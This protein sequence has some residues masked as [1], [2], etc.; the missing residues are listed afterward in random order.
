[1]S[2]HRDLVLGTAG[3]IDHGKTALVRALTGVDTDR[4]PAEK[5]R[6]ITIDLGF[7][8]LE[9][10]SDRLALVDVPGHERFIRNM[11][12]GATGL[13]LAM[14]VV[15]ADDSVMP[16]T[17]EHLEILRLL[18]IPA[19]LVAL[20][21]CDLADSGWVDLVEEEVRALVAGT[22]LEGAPIVRTSATTGRG[23]EDLKGALARLAA[24]APGRSDP[25]LFRMA[26]DRA[27]TVAG[28]GTV[29]TGTVAGGAVAVGD[30]L[31]WF[32][33]GR[34]VRVRGLQ[35]HE[36]PVDRVGRGARAAINLGGVHHAEIRRGQELGAPGYLRSTRVLSVEVRPAG[37]APRPLR[38]RG[39]YRLHLG[40]AEVTATLA[41]L[42]SNECGPGSEAMLGQLF[43]A[44]PVVAVYGE[45]FVL[46]EES[47]PA[48][49]GGGRVL[50]PVARRIR[51]RDL[52]ARERLGRL[53]SREPAERVSAALAFL[54]MAPWTERG[55]CRDTGLTPGE[56]PAV[57]AGLAASGALVELPVGPRRTVK[58]LAEVAAD[59]ED[60]VARA[61]GRLHAARPRLSAIRRPH[62]AAALPDL[63][64]DALVFGVVERLKARGA[65]V[66]D[67]RT[68]ALKDHEPKLSQGERRLKGELAEAIHAGGFSPPDQAE[69]SAKA[70]ARASVVPELLA[71]LVDEGRVVEVGHG[72]Y[73][74]FDVDAAMR[75][76]VAERLADGSAM[77][78]ADL[79]DLLGTTR[80]FAVPIGEYLDR[81]GLT[82]REGDLRRLGEP[83]AVATAEPSAPE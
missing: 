34:V 45:P 83:H 47:P 23:I 57:V 66:G 26:I 13:D 27:F 38:H 60:R 41:L 79:R 30:D 78:M 8:A 33:E 24:G 19:G 18:E 49:L 62:L 59:L 40:T 69:L 50:Q 58:V 5:Q 17:R 39:R 21:K 28:H 20:T 9:L 70:G 12:A 48:T 11:L 36:R 75:R 82:R 81:I 74:D 16:Q 72:L 51:R 31:E 15:A 43:L 35:R 55:L 46:R 64:G 29:V 67:E 4:L 61:L 73:L 25:G 6:G 3:H 80:K 42:E 32:P 22:F 71:L 76:R 53:R 14:L 56:V 37:D 65:V 44:E 10:G 7:A 77:T 54:G 1:M 68:V 2:G 63:P 52:A